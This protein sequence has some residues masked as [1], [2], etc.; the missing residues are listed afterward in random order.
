MIRLMSIVVAFALISIPLFARSGIDV[1]AEKVAIQKV[2]QEAYAE[3]LINTGNIEAAQRGFHPGFAILGVSDNS[4][5]KYPIY[6][7]IEAVEKRKKEGKIPPE[8]TVRF[9]YPLID[10]V[11]N[12]AIVKV[13]FI[14]GEKLKYTDYLSLYKFEEGWR[15]VNKIYYEHKE[16]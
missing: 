1:A 11:G 6:R 8:K 9:Q 16:E 4:L 13:E 10:I 12:A 7:W 2:I 14:E 5:W 3:G 15:I